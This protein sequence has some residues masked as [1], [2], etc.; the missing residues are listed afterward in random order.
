LNENG[1]EIEN[2]PNRPAQNQGAFVSSVGGDIGFV[3][4]LQGFDRSIRSSTK[5][6]LI[7]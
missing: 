5:V 6:R 7:K 2:R 3:Q 4:C 1:V